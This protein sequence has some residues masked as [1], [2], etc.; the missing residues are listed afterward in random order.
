MSCLSPGQVPGGYEPEGKSFCCRESH[1]LKVGILLA[2]GT[3]RLNFH[4]LLYALALFTH[5]SLVLGAFLAHSACLADIVDCLTLPWLPA[6]FFQASPCKWGTHR[7]D[8]ATRDTRESLKFSLKSFPSYLVENCLF[9]FSFL[10]CRSFY[11]T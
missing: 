6:L 1:S 9:F 2:S 10:N 8:Y 3:L 4:T 7:F 5:V 11:T